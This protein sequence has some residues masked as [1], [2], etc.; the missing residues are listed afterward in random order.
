MAKSTRTS[1]A[2]IQFH[3]RSPSITKN[4][5]AL[6]LTIESSRELQRFAQSRETIVCLLNIHVA[7]GHVNR[8]AHS[9]RARGFSKIRRAISIAGMD[10]DNDVF[11][12]VRRQTTGGA[13][14]CVCRIVGESEG[15]AGAITLTTITAI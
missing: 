11:G 12:L 10:R 5:V 9:G 1:T 4:A 3:R 13:V 2:L 8:L 6:R 14:D 15:E 7:S